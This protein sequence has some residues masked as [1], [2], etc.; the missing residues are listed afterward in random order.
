MKIIEIDY[1]REKQRLFFNVV[2]V[3]KEETVTRNLDKRPMALFVLLILNAA[4]TTT[5]ELQVS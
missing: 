3:V 5:T 1:T 2:C 4:T